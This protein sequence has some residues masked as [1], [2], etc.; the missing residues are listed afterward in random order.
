MQRELFS[1]EYRPQGNMRNLA[2]ALFILIIVFILVFIY[3]RVLLTG[4]GG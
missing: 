1:K 2:I 3:G 4:P